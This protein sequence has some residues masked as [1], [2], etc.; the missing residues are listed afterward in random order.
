MC[1]G[2]QRKSSGFR[3][4][5][6]NELFIRKLQFPLLTGCFSISHRCANTGRSIVRRERPLSGFVLYLAIKRYYPHCWDLRGFLRRR[7]RPIGLRTRSRAKSQQKL[8]YTQTRAHDFNVCSKL[9]DHVPRRLSTGTPR[10]AARA[11]A[12]TFAMNKQEVL[13]NNLIYIS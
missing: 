4:F 7:A 5:R 12:N 9:A 1:C 8:C 11:E 3:S 10:A 6:E 13:R 2:R